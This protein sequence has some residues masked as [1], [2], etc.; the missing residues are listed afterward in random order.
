MKEFKC[1]HCLCKIEQG[2]YVYGYD[3]NIFCSTE[4]LGEYFVLDCATNGFSY[5]N[6]EEYIENELGE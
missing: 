3:D 4:C 1:K 6:L 2:D 5:D